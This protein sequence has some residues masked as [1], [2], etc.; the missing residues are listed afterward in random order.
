MAKSMQLNEMDAPGS[1]PAALSESYWENWFNEHASHRGFESRLDE[2]S[3]WEKAVSF[4]I[5]ANGKAN[6]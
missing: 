4:G 6:R 1:Y 3:I 5:L 2:H